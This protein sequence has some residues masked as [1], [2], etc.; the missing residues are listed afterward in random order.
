MVACTLDYNWHHYVIAALISLFGGVI[1]LIPVKILQ[2]L[3]RRQRR[4]Q[5]RRQTAATGLRSTLGNLRNGAQ[6]I[7]AGSCIINKIIVSPVSH[8]YHS[9]LCI[10]INYWT[11]KRVPKR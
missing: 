2:V 9:Y 8:I 11:R 10:N 3:A 1:V 6:G 4:R 5:Y 7:L